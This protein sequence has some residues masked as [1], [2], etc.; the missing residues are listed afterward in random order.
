MNLIGPVSLHFNKA[1]LRRVLVHL[2][3]FSKSEQ[4][5]F[6]SELDEVNI[7]IVS[8]SVEFVGVM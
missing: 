2:Q 5:Q 4:F 1:I 8:E 7:A 3:N 6:V